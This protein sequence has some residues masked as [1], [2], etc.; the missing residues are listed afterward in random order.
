MGMGGVMVMASEAGDFAEGNKG[1]D[2]IA[3]G[4]GSD[5]LLGGQG[6]DVVQ[7]GA[8]NDF[9]SG[10]RGDDTLSGG[11]GADIF[12][13][14][15]DGGT[16]RVLDFSVAEGDRVQV[17]PGTMFQVMQMGADTVITLMGGGQMVLVGVNM[18]TLHGDWIF[19]A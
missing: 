11:A 4:A 10:D 2:T 3:G 12:H 7:G 14:V 17:D 19:G 16:D 13:A 6:N 18:A 15:A 1:A 8:G 5:T 9:I